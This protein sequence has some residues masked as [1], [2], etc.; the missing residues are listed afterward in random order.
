MFLALLLSLLLVYLVYAKRKYFTLRGPIPGSPPSFLVGNL[1]ETGQ[2]LRGVS[3]SQALVAHKKRFGDIFQLWMGPTRLIVVGNINDVQHIFAH[4]NIY[5]QGRSF[6]ERASVLFPNG[7]LCI[8][9]AAFKR[10]AAVTIPL[11]RR[12]KIVSNFDL[13]LEHT[14]RLLNIW[15]SYPSETIHTNIVR[16]SQN[17][18]LAIF[19][20]IGFDYD[21]ETLNADGRESSNELTQALYYAMGMFEIIFFSPRFLSILYTKVSRRYRRSRAIIEKYINQMIDKEL[22]ETPESRGERKRTCLIASLVASLQADEQQEARKPAEERKGKSI[23]STW[24]IAPYLF[25]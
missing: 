3:F 12:A 7:L 8:D 13:I 10:H 19:G 21:L 22:A 4:R 11:F 24:C 9:G 20:Y 15:R 2:L 17:L 1:I 6:L 14:D 25:V 16:Q 23:D 18:F 5:D